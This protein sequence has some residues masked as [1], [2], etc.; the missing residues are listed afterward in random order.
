[1]TATIEGEREC[2]YG[3]T[4]AELHARFPGER[5]DDFMKWMRGQTGTICEGRVY[6]YIQKEYRPSGCGP[7]GVVVYEW[8]V[9]RYE[10]GRPVID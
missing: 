5:H 6:D 3:L 1:M 4:E 7:H 8:D 10:D 9:K 2:M